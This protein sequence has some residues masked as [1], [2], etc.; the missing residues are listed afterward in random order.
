[1]VTQQL[2]Q[3]ILKA[4][5]QP[6]LDTVFG[7]KRL[8]CIFGHQIDNAY[9]PVKAHWRLFPKGYQY[10]NNLVH[11]SVVLNGAKQRSCKV[12]FASNRTYT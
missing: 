6:P 10:D 12:F 3:N 5:Q 4:I 8:D 2:Q 11:E 1:M 7:I 9:W